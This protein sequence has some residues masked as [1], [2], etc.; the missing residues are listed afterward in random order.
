LEGKVVRIKVVSKEISYEELEP[1]IKELI[2][3]GALR[4]AICKEPINKD[5]IA[6]VFSEDDMT[7]AI[8]TACPGTLRSTF[9][10]EGGTRIIVGLDERDAVRL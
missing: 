7:W 1:R 9:L 6:V 5:N 10:P 4:C 2:E 3:S 8:C